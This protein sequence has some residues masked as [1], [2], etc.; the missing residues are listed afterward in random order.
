MSSLRNAFS[1]EKHQAVKGMSHKEKS[2]YIS[3]DEI[4]EARASYGDNDHWKY[5]REKFKE[6]HGVAVIDTEKLVMY[7]TLDPNILKISGHI[8]YSITEPEA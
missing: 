5:V 1:R 6:K 3:T 4:F 2:I 8:G 7:S